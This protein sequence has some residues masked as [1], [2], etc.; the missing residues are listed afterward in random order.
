M[1]EKNNY[2]S[3]ST[4][5]RPV[6]SI[7]STAQHYMIINTFTLFAGITTETIVTSHTN[8]IFNKQYFKKRK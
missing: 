7:A 5:Y 8:C 4:D 2:Y 1:K 6:R 3:P